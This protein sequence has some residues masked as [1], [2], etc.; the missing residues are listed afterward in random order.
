MKRADRGFVLFVVLAVTA[1][2]AM[3]T[4]T[5]LLTVHQFRD[6]EAR[7]R[8]AVA[9]TYLA[10]AGLQKAA[11]ELASGARNY[12]GEQHTALGDGEYSVRVLGSPANGRFRVESTGA[13][14]DGTY[15]L[16]EQTLTAE[17]I[18]NGGRARIQNVARMKPYEAHAR[19][20]KP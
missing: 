12:P 20:L 8:K 15:V 14:V 2:L 1:T 18:V 7:S 4:T 19:A 6:R 17:I 16:C 9:A 10:E 13:L 11:A 3:L 5:F